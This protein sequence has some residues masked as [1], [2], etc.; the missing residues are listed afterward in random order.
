MVYQHFF[1]RL[2][3]EPSLLSGQLPYLSAVGRFIH[4]GAKYA[5]N[6]FTAKVLPAPDP[7]EAVY[8]A[9]TVH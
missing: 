7:A 6:A 1:C 3:I 8:S 4:V 9:P 2:E 5:K